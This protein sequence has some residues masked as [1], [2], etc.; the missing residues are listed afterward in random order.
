[1]DDVEAKYGF[2]ATRYLSA[3][4]EEKAEFK[5]LAK[6]KKNRWL[7][8]LKDD[9][10]MPAMVHFEEIDRVDVFIWKGFGKGHCFYKMK[11]A[12]EYGG[13]LDAK[14]IEIEAHA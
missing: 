1:M 6:L 2:Y 10:E 8:T 5:C 7:K 12:D 14:E 11:D 9:P 13:H 3:K 4:D